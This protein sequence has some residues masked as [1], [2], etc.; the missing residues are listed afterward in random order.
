MMARQLLA[1]VALVS[2]ATDVRAAAAAAAKR[3]YVGVYLHDVAKFDQKDGVF[4]VDLDL[5]LKW[6]G[7]FKPAEV[8]LA[9]AGEVQRE[10]VA[11]E[12]DGEWHS[13]RYRVRGTL[14]GEFPLQAF[15]LDV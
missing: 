14:R 11:E 3:V 2:A 12:S 15:P 4:D 7:E 13:A 8:V 5:W 1:L 10:L 6:L 9:N